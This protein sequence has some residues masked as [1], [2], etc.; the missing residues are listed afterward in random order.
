MGDA[1]ITYTGHLSPAQ[2]FSTNG[3]I[4]VSAA[5]A[6]LSNVT[7]SP[8]PNPHN[9]LIVFVEGN[10][11]WTIQG[12]VATPITHAGL[13]PANPAPSKTGQIVFSDLDP[14]TG[15]SQLYVCNFDGSALHRMTSSNRQH[16]QPSWSPSGAKIVFVSNGALW[17]VSQD[18]SGEAILDVTTSGLQPNSYGNP[19][20]SP[21]GAKIAFDGIDIVKGHRAVYVANSTGG[22][23]PEFT[24]GYN[25]DC[26]HPC[27]APDGGAIA[28]LVFSPNL[29]N[30][31]IS[32][33]NAPIPGTNVRGLCI[34]PDN[35]SYE[36]PSFSPDGS[37]IVFEVRTM[38]QPSS[39]DTQLVATRNL[40]TLLQEALSEEVEPSSPQWSPYF[41]K[42]TFVGSGGQMGSASGFLLTELGDGFASFLSIAATT[43]SKLTI[44]KQPSGSGDAAQVYIAKADAITK[45]V[46]SNAYYGAYTAVS[47]TGATQAVISVS[48]VSG[49]VGLVAPFAEPAKLTRA[50][51][52]AC[53]YDGK[54]LGV[55][56]GKGK[57]LAPSGA[58]HIELDKKT[59]ALVSWR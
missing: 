51:E 5:G 55:Y 16:G 1:T 40:P 24:I 2:A 46:Y 37:S 38:N 34:P 32:I 18:G 53:A 9:S 54:F 28:Y 41:G 20:W 44:T 35:Q 36:S 22:S 52:T 33:A 58:S 15:F 11:L 21:D 14:V 23:A 25:T 13:N 56:D 7:L 29:G 57:N 4:T 26:S 47:T 43:P 17:T 59:G 6:A 10:E 12:Q 3:V 48:S 50:S 39:L 42:K 19:A 27:W 8:A 49:Q 31:S 30:E 45:L